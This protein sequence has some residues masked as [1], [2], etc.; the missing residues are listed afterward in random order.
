M[1][2]TA[3]AALITGSQAVSAGLV[4]AA[5]AE[6]GMAVTLVGA[7]TGNKDMM[8]VGGIMGIVGGVGGLINSAVQ[9]GSAAAAGAAGA[10]GGGAAA[11]S[12]VSQTAAGVNGAMGG[13]VNNAGGWVSGQAVGSAGTEIASQAA[14]Q[15]GVNVLDMGAQ[16][17]GSAAQAAGSGAGGIISGASD[18]S[19]ASGSGALMN[20]AQQ[21]IGGSGAIAK[22]VA[23]SATNTGVSETIKGAVGEATRQS[24]GSIWGKLSGIGEWM[25]KNKTL[26]GVLINVGS[27]AVL[28]AMKGDPDKELLDI[29]R[30]EVAIAER[31]QYNESNAPAPGGVMIP[32]PRPIINGVRQ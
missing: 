9:G 1:A 13:V 22:E 30:R 29:R 11:G 24:T 14:Q 28:G 27:N 6:V 4:L 23:R 25:D 32:Q 5:V 15:A 16:A 7:V 17:A 2:F 26:S 12:G 8:K 20:N 19:M 3:T 18:I 31:R 21:A 10:S